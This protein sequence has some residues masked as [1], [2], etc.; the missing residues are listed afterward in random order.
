MKNKRGS[1]ILFL[2]LVLFAGYTALMVL[3]QQFD[4]QSIGPENSSVG[5]AT[6]NRA[7]F[8]FFGGEF[9]PTW[10]KISEITGYIALA[11]AAGFGLVGVIQ[12]IKRRSLRRVDHELLWLGAFYAV[13]IALYIIFLY[14]VVNYRPVIIDEEGLESSFPSSHTLLAVFVF[15]TGIYEAFRLFAS[16]MGKTV[17]TVGSILAGICCLLT[18]S[19]RLM[20]CAH[21]ITDI[22]G[23]ILLGAAFALLYIWVVKNLKRPLL[24][25]N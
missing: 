4:V 6:L 11:T 17:L 24:T 8:L 14:V 1:G 12:W 21:W 2:S 22:L 5:F 7:V 19:G 10:Y 13:I 16:K 23:G 15:S 18:V 25:K 20:S 3:V 9:Q